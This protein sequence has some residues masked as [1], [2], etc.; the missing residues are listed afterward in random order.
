MKSAEEEDNETGIAGGKKDR[1]DVG[2]ACNSAETK[3]GERGSVI[4]IM[5]RFFLFFIL[6]ILEFR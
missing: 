4:C 5:L 2:L 6:L 3:S 1:R